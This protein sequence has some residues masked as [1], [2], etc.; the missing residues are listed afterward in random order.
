MKRQVII[1]ISPDRRCG[2]PCIRDTRITVFDIFEYL[3]G[4]MTHEELLEEFPRLTEK[5]L[6]ACYD[7]ITDEQMVP[8]RPLVK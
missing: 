5:D 7:Y 8:R 4:G 3:A 6:L 1:T 2:K